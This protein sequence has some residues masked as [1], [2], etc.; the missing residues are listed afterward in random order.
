MTTTAAHDPDPVSRRAPVRRWIVGIDG[1]DCARHAALWAR[2]NIADRADELELITTWSVPVS[3]GY[4]VFEPMVT[5]A[6]MDLIEKAANDTVDELASQL[7]PDTSV[8]ITTIVARGGAASVL[9]EASSQGSLVILGSRG[10]G[11]FARLL[12]GSTSTQC[13]THSTIPTVIVPHE[14]PLEDIKTILVAFDGS[15]N[16]VAALRWAVDFASPGTTINCTTVWDVSPITVGSDRYFFPEA[17][18][19]ARDRFHHLVSEA[20]ADRDLTGIEVQRHFVEGRPKADLAR[21]AGE[22]D[23]SVMGAR[24]HGAITAALLGSVSTSLLHC[25]RR[26]MVVVPHAADDQE[27]SAPAHLE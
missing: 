24:G 21:L 18:D 3:G 23:L 6:S 17:V 25:V 20:L 11:G 2:K 4:P 14:S 16:S 22:F 12:L 27:L 13:A 5:S 19:L 8:P 7:R 9:L 1:S 15:A 10:R 26:P